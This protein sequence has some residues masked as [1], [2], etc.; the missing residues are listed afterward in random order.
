MSTAL[1]LAHQQSHPPGEERL[2]LEAQL[3]Q[4]QKMAAVGQFTGGIAHDFNNILTTVLMNAELIAGDIPP[5]HAEAHKTA[6]EIKSAAQRGAALVRK[7]MTFSRQE[8]LEIQP[9]DY[10]KLCREAAAMLRRFLPENIDIRTALDEAAG[11]IEGDSSAVE[12]IIINLAT[13][14]RDAMPEG[15]ALAITTERVTVDERA[16]HVA[17]GCG[18]PGDY[19]SLSVSDSG[20]GMNEETKWKL[21][22]PFFTTKPVGPGTGLGMAMVDGLV[23]QHNGFVTV[24]SEP[25]HGTTVTV[26][27]PA[28]NGQGPG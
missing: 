23:Q 7:L 20:V 19:V 25:G 5:S 6:N 14:A 13:N 22:K 9:V 2:R 26:Y 28:A 1:A 8:Q 4:A 15:G 3:R 12:Q 10:T 18:R 24:E 21:F 16:S 27:F 17:R 11:P